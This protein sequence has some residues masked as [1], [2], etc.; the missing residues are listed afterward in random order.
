[1]STPTQINQ[2]YDIIF[3]GGAP[4]SSSSISHSLL[5][6]RT[7]YRW[8]CWLRCRR[9]S[10]SGRPGLAHPRTRGGP[11]NVQQPC[12]QAARAVLVAPC[13]G[14]THRACAYQPPERGA[15]GPLDTGAM[16]TMS[17][18]RRECQLYVFLSVRFGGVGEEGKIN[19]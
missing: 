16:R 19:G 6:E 17:R 5:T 11:P 4:F 8:R 10:C 13:A 3:A 2:E 7:S 14:F 12:A 1:M 18:R 9:P 15:R